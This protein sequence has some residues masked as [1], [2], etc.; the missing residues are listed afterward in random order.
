M[1]ISYILSSIGVF[2]VVIIVLVVVLLVAKKYLSPSGKV[3][4]TINGDTVLEV[5]Q[6][7]SVMNTLNENGIYLPSACGGKASCGQCKLQILSGGGEILDSEKPHFSRKEIKDNWRLGCQAKIKGDMEVK[8]PE[9]VMGVKEWECTVIGNRN[10]ATFIKEYKVALPPGEHMHFEP[11]SYAQIRIPAFELDYDKDFDKAL[12]G[13]TYL[14]AWEKFGLFGL[15][16]KNEEPTIRAYSMAN[17]PDEGDIITLNVR[18]ATPPF[19]PKDQG[20]GFIDVNPGIASSYIFSLKPGDKVTMS[21]PYGEFRP[22]YGTGR[23][24]IW[25]GGGAGMAPLRAQ[26]MHML[27]G[28]GIAPEDRQRE[29]HYFY[30]ARAL[31][32]IPVLDDFLQ[33]EKDFPNFHFHL[34]LDRPDPKADAAGVKYTPG[35]VAPVMG[36]TYLKQHESPEDCEYYLCGPPMMAKTVLDLLHSLG[37]EDDMIRFDNFGG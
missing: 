37:V 21:G 18:I 6:G 27:K 8:V 16:C 4:L 12:I 9:S 25:V 19:K 10:V 34:A 17:Y 7:N 33:L 15:K 3:K 2:L 31:E 28:N 29:M 11:G 14:P 1:N 32:E 20:P 26:I 13:D 5:E 23:E 30:G 24:M 22:Q 36:D 35:F